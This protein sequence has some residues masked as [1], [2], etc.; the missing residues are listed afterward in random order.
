MLTILGLEVIKTKFV[1]RLI[2]FLDR[3]NIY[4]TLDAS[5]FVVRLF[6]FLLDLE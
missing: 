3:R 2:F 4:N 6:V 1:F 5:F